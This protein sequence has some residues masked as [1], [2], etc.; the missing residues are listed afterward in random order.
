MSGSRE[1]VVVSSRCQVLGPAVA[2][3]LDAGGWA[4]EVVDLDGAAAALATTRPQAMVV[5]AAPVA[6][7]G[8]EQGLD[9][10]A[11]IPTTAA[12]GRAALADGPAW[13]LRRL[14]LV[15]GAGSQVGVPGTID[16]AVATGGLIGLAE[17][18]ARLGGPAGV[19][20]NAVVPGLVDDGAG[21][22]LGATDVAWAQGVA[23][24]SPIRRLVTPDEVAA[25]VAFLCS[26]AASYVSGTVW[27]VTGGLGMGVR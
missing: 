8:G 14:V 15:A 21:G 22:V 10:A 27:P 2:A 17:G 1:R 18:L 23:R 3:A 19:T 12:L 6:L 26:D 5:V 13:G 16:G 20:A 4:A 11:T 9:E 25:A 24:T 7:D